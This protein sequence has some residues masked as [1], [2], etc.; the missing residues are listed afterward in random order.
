MPIFKMPLSPQSMKIPKK[1]GREEEEGDTLILDEVINILVHSG[2]EGD[3]GKGLDNDVEGVVLVV[4]EGRDNVVGLGLGAIK[5]G[6]VEGWLSG[7]VDN[8]HGRGMV[9]E[10]NEVEGMYDDES[11]LHGVCGVDEVN[12]SGDVV[13]GV[14]ASK[15]AKS[16]VLNHW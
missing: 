1:Q 15:D 8:E 13:G 14:D 12:H 16:S 2:V 9:G 4:I 5:R 7:G 6:A 3:G 10:L 11:G